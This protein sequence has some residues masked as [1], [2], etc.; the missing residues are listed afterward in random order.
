MASATWPVRAS[1]FVTCIIDQIYPEV[2]DSTV[3]LLRRLGVELDF[4]AAQTCCGQPAFNSGFWSDAKPLARRTIELLQHD[5]YVVV[6]S[7]SCASMMRVFYAELFHDEPAMQQRIA[8]LASRTYELT[9]FIVDVLGID[10]LSAY[11]EAEPSQYKR[12]ITYHEGCHLRRELH[13]QTQ[14]RTLLDSLPD[15]ELVEMEQSE[16]CCGFG[17]TFSVKFP[18]ISGAMLNDK[19]KYAGKT[20][21]DSITACDSSCLMH[22]GGGIAKR[23]MD[24]QPQHIAQVLDDALTG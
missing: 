12:K 16:V 5:R 4:P 13:A 10:D 17:G 11:V 24:I 8:S 9:E 7:G 22:I 23:R 21:A 19:L 6:P 3:R 1:L 18:E 14:P 20:G 2:G 15:V